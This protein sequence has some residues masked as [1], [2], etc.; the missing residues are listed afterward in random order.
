MKFMVTEVQLENV[1][2]KN[3]KL[4]LDFIRTSH[5]SK[6]PLYGKV[7]GHFDGERFIIK[8]FVNS[9]DLTDELQEYLDEVYEV[10]SNYAVKPIY[11]QWETVK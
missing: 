6:N 10:A 9:Y 1:I 11:I 4:I 2:N 7:R 8:M 3:L 5:L